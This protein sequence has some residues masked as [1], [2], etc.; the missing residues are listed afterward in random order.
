[1]RQ[2]LVCGRNYLA[3]T[4]RAD[5]QRRVHRSAPTSARNSS[6]RSIDSALG[7][8]AFPTI[9]TA[10]PAG[11]GGAFGAG[12]GFAGA[13]S[14]GLGAGF[15]D[16]GVEGDPVDDGS[17]QSGVGEHGAPFTERQVGGD[18]DR[19]P[20]LSFGDD[21]EQQFGS[22][23]VDLDIAELVEAEWVQAPVAG[24][25]ARQDPFVGGFDEFVDQP[26]GGEVA[27]PSALFAGRQPQPDEQVGLAGPGVTEQ[28]DWFA[29]VHVVT[30]GQMSEG[31]GG[32]A[33]DGVDVELRQS[34]QPRDPANDTHAESQR[35]A[36]VLG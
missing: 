14:V 21:L 15:D 8:G 29:G 36:L 6:F 3:P 20:F 10:R 32:D 16:V 5:R 25:H 30:G 22:A 35:V 7:G 33:G 28:H 27:D 1:M 23:R 9:Y 2:C 34:F 24:H 4:C 18:R 11:L 31:R 19:G 13:E 17:N 26:G 12:G